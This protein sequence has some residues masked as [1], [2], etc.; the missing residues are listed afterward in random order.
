M[1]GDILL[2]QDWIT[3]RIPNVKQCSANIGTGAFRLCVSNAMS[4]I[5]HCE[6]IINFTYLILIKN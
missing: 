3:S 4:S 1:L 5:A 6:I 2:H